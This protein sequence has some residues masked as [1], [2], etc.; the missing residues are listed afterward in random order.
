MNRIGVYCDGVVIISEFI[1][2]L[3]TKLA[4][5]TEKTIDTLVNNL[6]PMIDVT[7]DVLGTAEDFVELVDAFSEVHLVRSLENISALCPFGIVL[8]NELKYCGPPYPHK[9]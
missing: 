1:L 3:D 8:I 7:A 5:R 6:D 9:T 2:R 4:S